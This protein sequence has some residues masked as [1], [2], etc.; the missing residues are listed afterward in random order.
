MILY[1]LKMTINVS[2]EKDKFIY[3]KNNQLVII[4]CIIKNKE[5]YIKLIVN[6]FLSV[7]E[8]FSS[9]LSS[10]TIG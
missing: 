10:I 7:S 1:N 4:K 5:N 3:L 6:T 2:K 8:F 9:P